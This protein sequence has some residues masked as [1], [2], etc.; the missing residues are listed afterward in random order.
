MIQQSESAY[1]PLFLS[2]PLD[3]LILSNGPGEITSWVLP[4]VKA[5]RD[6]FGNNRDLVRISVILS[7]CPHASGKETAIARTFPEVDRVQSPEYFFTFLWRGQTQDNWDWYPQGMVIFLG[8]DQF[9]PLVIGSRLKY[10]TLVYAE[11]DARWLPWIDSFALGQDSVQAKIPS[12]YHHKCRVVGNLMADLG[13]IYQDDYSPS[14]QEIIGLLPGSKSAKLTQ[15]VPLAVGIAEAIAQVRPAT[16]FIL[17]LAPT[18]DVKTLARFAQKETNPFIAKINGITGE[19]KS[20]LG[21]YLQTP[22]GVKIELVT[23]FPVFDLLA[24]CRLCLTT[25]GANTAQLGTLAVP[26]LV[27]IPTHQL[28]AMRSWDGIPG[29]LANLPGLGYY[30]ARLI[31]WAVIRQ[32]RLYAWPNLWAKEAIVPELLGEIKAESVASLVLELLKHP[33][34]LQKMRDR[35]LQIRPQSGAASRLVEMIEPF[36]DESSLY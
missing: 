5:L 16:R 4:V 23:R 31:N 32:K 33:E 30:F 20:D 18:L 35:L 21:Y 13:E 26:M 28:D 1:P 11:W 10:R 6:K 7:P 25:V 15:G 17:P 27:L 29:L 9:Y 2:K 14:D 3:F 8:G 19:L 12:K 24:Q 36:T 34:E 22:S